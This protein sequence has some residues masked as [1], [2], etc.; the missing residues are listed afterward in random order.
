MGSDS[1]LELMRPAFD[2]LKELAIPAEVRVLSAHRTPDD[3]LQLART[4]AAR[5]VRV[6]IAGAGWAAALPGALAGATPLPVIGVPLA[7]SPLSGFDALLSV[8]Q[9]PPGVPVATVAVNGARNAGLLAAR[10]LATG[11]ESLRAR[12]EQS[13]ARMADNVRSRDA[14]VRASFAEAREG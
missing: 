6:I 3:A 2:A 4:A 13:Q 5:G 12:I 14:S 1:D 11:D 9:M 10:I 8:V 7:T